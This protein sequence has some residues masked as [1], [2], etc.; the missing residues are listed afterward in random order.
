LELLKL[1]F[2]IKLKPVLN[3]YFIVSVSCQDTLIAKCNTRWRL[4]PRKGPSM[5]QH[6]NMLNLV[7]RVSKNI[8][9]VV[10]MRVQWKFPN[11][12]CSNDEFLQWDTMKEDFIMILN[13][14]QDCRKSQQRLTFFWSWDFRN[15]SFVLYL[16][17]S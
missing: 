1:K 3:I 16:V 13:K 10:K 8:T 11:F 17:N 4:Y 15:A 12:R 9:F 14:F 5:H 6:V 2:V 7:Q